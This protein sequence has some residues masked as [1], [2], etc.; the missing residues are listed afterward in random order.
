[1]DKD[2]SIKLFEEKTIR[3]RWDAE[4]GKWFFSVVDVIAVLTDS[5]N[6]RRY[7][8]DLKRKLKA[9]GSQLYEK[10]VQLKMLSAE[11]SELAAN[12]SQL[13]MRQSMR[14]DDY[15]PLGQTP[16]DYSMA[17]DIRRKCVLKHIDAHKETLNI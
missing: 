11:G 6:P 12:C 1:M 13:K 14:T 5:E 2:N 10:I 16:P 17:C 3:A 8:S 15:G 7:W 9:E 4:N